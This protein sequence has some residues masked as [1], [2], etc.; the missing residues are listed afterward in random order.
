MKVNSNGKVSPF[1]RKL[2][3]SSESQY[4]DFIGGRRESNSTKQGSSNSFEKSKKLLLPPIGAYGEKSKIDGDVDDGIAEVRAKLMSELH[5]VANKINVAIPEEGEEDESSVAAARPWNLRKRRAACTAPNDSGRGVG[6]GSGLAR[7]SNLKN[8]ERQQN[9]SPSWNDNSTIK[10]LRLR[11]SSLEQSNI[12]KK[13]ILSSQSHFL[14]K[15]SRTKGMG[16]KRT[17]NI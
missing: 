15:R 9:T 3:P 12:G 17:F 2:S 4:E 8:E 11:F 10:S 14:D 5:T 1:D 6:G 7:C 16:V 13:E